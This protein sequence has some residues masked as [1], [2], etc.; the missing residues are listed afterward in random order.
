MQVSDIY[1]TTI[2]PDVYAFSIWG[3]IYAAQ[4]LSF[5]VLLVRTE[6]FKVS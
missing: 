3:L 5:I 4:I 2:T 6:K 1:P